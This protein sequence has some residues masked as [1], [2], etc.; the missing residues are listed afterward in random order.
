MALHDHNIDR[1]LNKDNIHGSTISKPL[2]I[3]GKEQKVLSIEKVSVLS[4]VSKNTQLVCLSNH[5]CRGDNNSFIVQQD[6]QKPRTHYM[7]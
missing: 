3:I 1:I 5:R 2:A 4:S 7:I 6:T